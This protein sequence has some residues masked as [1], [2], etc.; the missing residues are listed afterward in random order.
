MKKESYP[1]DLTD[2]QW[3]IL[4]PLIPP[5][6]PGG[7]P[8]KTNIRQVLNAIFYLLRSGCAWRL[9]PHDFPPWQ[10]VYNYFRKWKKDG[11]WEKI[12]ETLHQE[13]RK[14]DGRELEPSASII[15]SQSVKTTEKGGIK[16]YDAHKHIKGRKRHILV[17][18]MGLIIAV[19]ISAANVQDRDGAKLV[20]QKIKNCMK[21]LCLIWADGAYAG[22][23]IDWVKDKCGWKLKIQ[24]GPKAAK[25]FVVRPWLWIVERTFAWLGRYR[26]LSKDYEFLTETSEAMIYIAMIHIMV[27]RLA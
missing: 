15:D 18:T 27:R 22:K 5:Q 21:R 4:K 14:E 1:T 13:C 23:L 19:V 16:G 3:K 9:I 20:L 7:R 10:T 26:R 25:G 2:E 6:K 8:R 17:D 24:K 11:I 12:H